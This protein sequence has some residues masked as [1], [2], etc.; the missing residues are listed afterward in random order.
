MAAGLWGRELDSSAEAMPTSAYA[1]RCVVEVRLGSRLAVGAARN[2][3]SLRF[4]EMKWSS[5]PGV[6]LCWQP[7]NQPT[8]IDSIAYVGSVR[9][10]VQRATL[11]PMILDGDG[12]VHGLP[13]NE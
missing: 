9:D 4:V 8:A 10:V 2:D 5:Q 6:S 11:G 7:R 3:A 1:A 13:S 12:R